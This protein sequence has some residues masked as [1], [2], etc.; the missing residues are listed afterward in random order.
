MLKALEGLPSNVV[1][2]EA[3]GYIEASDYETVLDPVLESALAT[4]DKVRFLYLLGTEFEGLTAGAMWEDAKVGLGHWSSYEKI[5]LVTDHDSYRD[6][7]VLM[8]RLMQGSIK[9]FTVAEL[10]AAKEWIAS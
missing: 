7:V 8:A 4:H 2:F 10:D 5:A 3:V 6:A 9:A 1:A